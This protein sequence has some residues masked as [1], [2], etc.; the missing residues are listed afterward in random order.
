MAEGGGAT[1]A[2]AGATDALGRT[3][4][5]GVEILEIAAGNGAGEVRARPGAAGT[6]DGVPA[7]PSIPEG[8]GIGVT[9][10]AGGATEARL[11]GRGTVGRTLA[12]MLRGAARYVPRSRFVAAP[13]SST[14][15]AR[16][17]APPGDHGEGEWIGAPDKTD[18]QTPF[19]STELLQFCRGG[20]L[21]HGGNPR[22]RLD[23]LGAHRS[24]HACSSSSSP[25][26]SSSSKKNAD[27]APER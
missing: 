23:L 19:L 22:Y 17:S 2:G 5:G 13:G 4:G 25:S 1:L 18:D 27:L 20:A 16:S 12:L 7:R 3:L 9:R 15:C 11:V 14:I 24:S 10:G 21:P 6:V 8:G 26:A